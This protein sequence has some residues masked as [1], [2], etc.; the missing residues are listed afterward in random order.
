MSEIIK[1]V[2]EKN[3]EK[4]VLNCDTPVVVDFWAPWCGPCKI[5]GPIFEA[6]AEELKDKVKFV[7]VDVDES[8]ILNE[9]YKIRSI[10]TTIYFDDGEAKASKAGALTKPHL[11]DFIEA[12]MLG[13]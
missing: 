2:P 8:P 5:Y 7:K 9:K 13:Q 6:V 4:E 3:F 1:F 10:P 11:K 12:T